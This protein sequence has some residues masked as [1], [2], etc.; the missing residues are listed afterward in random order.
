ML[1]IIP[2]YNE[3]DN[4]RSLLTE[5]KAL[6][7]V[8]IV[9]INDHSKDR[10]SLICHQ[11]NVNVIDLPCN[12]GIGGAVQTGYIFAYKNAYDIAIQVD[13]DGQHDPK[14]IPELLQPI[15]E[16]EA[17]LVI[18]SRYINK[19]GFQSTWLRRVG[20]K[21]FSFLI[22]VLM[23]QKI[24]DPTSGFRACNRKLIEMFATNYPT[25]YPEP[26][27]IVFVKRKGLKIKEVPVIMKERLGGVSSIRSLK[28]AHYMIKV[29]FAVVIDA[30]RA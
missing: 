16:G 17:D 21:Y 29:T 5:L 8:E 7:T 9:V 14:F 22:K 20:I 30:V 18:G 2:A 13:G 4:I 1:V 6:N 26:E 10:T 19:I 28:S 11:E 23:K 24:T 3:E 15:M 27:S 12:L 25:D